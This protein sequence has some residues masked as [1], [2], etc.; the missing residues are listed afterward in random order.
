[1]SED[2][3]V[4]W[5]LLSP[6]SMHFIQ[7]ACVFRGYHAIR[8]LIR[9]R[10]LQLT[11]TVNYCSSSLY[12]EFWSV[13]ADAFSADASELIMSHRKF[14]LPGFWGMLIDPSSCFNHH[15]DQ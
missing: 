6:N 8:R 4:R 7:I 5:A 15:F 12:R 10:T 13:F 1:M 2:P 11:H 14:S 3:L 9:S